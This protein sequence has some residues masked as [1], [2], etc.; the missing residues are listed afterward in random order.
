MTIHGCRQAS[1]LFLHQDDCVL[2]HEGKTID[3]E[4]RRLADASK[5]MIT[6]QEREQLWRQIKH[7]GETIERSPAG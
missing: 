5:R 4:T 6:D 3:D 7:S 1:E 2:W